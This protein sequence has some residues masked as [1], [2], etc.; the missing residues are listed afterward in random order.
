NPLALVEIVG[1]AEVV[2]TLANL[3]ENDEIA[4]QIRAV[5][6]LLELVLG[7]DVEGKAAAELERMRAEGEK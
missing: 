6:E 2:I 7:E 1:E 4:D 5:I 3:A